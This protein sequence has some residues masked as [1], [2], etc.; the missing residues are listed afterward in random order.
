MSNITVD[1]RTGSVDLF[2][3]LRRLGLPCTLGRISFGDISFIGT[4]NEGVPV[5]IGVEYKKVRDV[6]QCMTDGRF[7][8][9]QLPGLVNSYSQIYLLIEGEIRP[10]PS[11]GI[12]EIK[13]HKGFWY[14]GMVG[15]RR[16]MYRDL[17]KWLLTMSIKGGLSI[18]QTSTLQETSV[19]LSALY[20]WWGGDGNGGWDSHKSHLAFNVSADIRFGAGRDRALLVRPSVLR[21]IAAE[22]PGVGYEKSGEIEKF[23]GS[24]E[25]LFF[26]TES[27]IACVPGIGKG[28]A[29]KVWGALHR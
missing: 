26:A 4:G 17:A 1:D 24:M 27:D 20:N 7:A 23:F 3:I 2:P 29:A 21:R 15:T 18:A 9:H 11:T 6:L 16:F 12:L 5:P 25:A 14:E 22:L 13:S 8:G 10:H 28:I 19:W